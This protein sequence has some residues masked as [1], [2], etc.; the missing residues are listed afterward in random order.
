MPDV[1]IHPTNFHLSRPLVAFVIAGTKTPAKEWRV[2]RV[3]PLWDDLSIRDST[4]DRPTGHIE[5]K[6][7]DYQPIQ[8]VHRNFI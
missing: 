3:E 7:F 5:I 8:S 2:E 4:I 6:A 1:I